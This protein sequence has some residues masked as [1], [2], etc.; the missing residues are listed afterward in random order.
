MKVKAFSILATFLLILSMIAPT[1]ATAQAAQKNQ[2]DKGTSVS[3]N[4]SKTAQEKV[5]KR[6]QD[7]FKKDD[8]VTFLV[9]FKE[10]ADTTAVAKQA[11]QDAKKHSLSADKAKFLQ[12]SAVVSELKS[13][14]LETQANVVSFLESQEAAGAVESFH[15]YHIVNGIAVTATKEIA[16]QIAAFS[17]VDKILPN[18]E[19]RLLGATITKEPTPKSTLENVEWNVERVQAPQVWSMG[20]D[21]SGTVVGSLDSGVQW[22]HPALMEKYRGY[23]SA[24]GEVDHTYSFHD[25]FGAQ[26]APYD[27]HGHG[28]HVT[29]TMVGSEPD[30]SNQVGVAP[31]A[32]WI[33]AKVFN[34]AGSTT[35]Q[36]LLDA[37]EWMLAPGGRVDMA[38]DVVN[39]SWG[40]GP[41]LDE[42]YWDAVQAWRDAEIF[43]EFSA[44]NVDLFNPGG[45]GS[46]AVPANYPISFATGATDI[47]D[48]L[49]GFSLRGPSPYDEIKPDIS[50]PGVNIRSSV[51]GSGYEGGW[52]GTSMSGP[53][54]S[55]VAALL[56]QV[57]ANI[58]VDE[59]EQVL[60]NTAIPMTDD[61][62]PETPNNG[63][64]HGLV[65]AYDAVSSILDGLGTIEGQVT[66]EGEDDEAPTYEHT[67]P[68]ETYAGMD[69]DL[70][71]DVSDNISVTSVTLHYEQD[72]ETVEVTANRIS[73]DYKSGEYKATIPG[74]AIAEGSL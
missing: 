16:E 63:F 30:G 56:R 24:T 61:E 47:N 54:V 1:M 18:E 58:T 48:N 29:G 37:A 23:D 60:I 38:P 15:S 57:N 53:A 12:R 62:Y 73:G 51:P 70:H 26:D 31:G 43:P 25:G 3:V 64:G 19:R 14:A 33:A 28:T 11:K 69:L 59:M 5:S 22:D 49:A 4:E 67:A 41:G 36:I 21:G 17:E 34:A 55:A 10:K 7:A 13:V 74:D 42:W 66:Q 44:G 72:G 50:A 46:V 32:K 27:D 65:N 52:N 6:L 9:K 8:T 20:I 39:N 45:P 2:S 35:D 40:G 68:A 71:I